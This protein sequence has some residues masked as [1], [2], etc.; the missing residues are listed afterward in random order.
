MTD[1]EIFESFA[2]EYV[3][4]ISIGYLDKFFPLINQTEN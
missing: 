4:D 2:N 1:K 3:N